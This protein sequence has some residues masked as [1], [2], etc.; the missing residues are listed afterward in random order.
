MA[1]TTLSVDLA[2]VDL[3]DL[4][5]WAEGPPHE[6]FARMRAEA[7]VRWNPSADGYGFWSLTGGAEI[8]E[9]S[10]NPEPFPTPAPARPARPRRLC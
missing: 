1:S 3:T 10:E 7:P 9:V 2:S 4:D 8:T 6:L 5:L